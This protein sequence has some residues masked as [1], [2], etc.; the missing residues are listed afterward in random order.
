MSTNEETIAHAIAVVLR[1]QWLEPLQERIRR[2][3]EENIERRTEVRFLK[4]ML[5]SRDEK[6]LLFP[7]ERAH[8]LGTN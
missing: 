6:H 3:E 5:N 1:E 8:R 4:D 2:L 7:G